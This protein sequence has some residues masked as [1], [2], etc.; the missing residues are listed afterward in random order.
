E[1]AFHHYAAHGRSPSSHIVMNEQNT[2]PLIGDELRDA[3]E[4]RT[5]YRYAG[6][7]RLQND[8]WPRFKPLRRH[9]KHIDRLEK[10]PSSICLQLG[11]KLDSRVAGRGTCNSGAILLAVRTGSYGKNIK[12]DL[13]GFR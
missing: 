11:Q 1:I 10:F 5:N 2:I 12:L 7:K 9:N 13:Q 6:C 8:Q 4:V 3:A